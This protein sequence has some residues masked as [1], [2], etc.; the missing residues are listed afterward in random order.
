[1]SRSANILSNAFDMNMIL[2]GTVLMC[3]DSNDLDGKLLLLLLL[4]VFLLAMKFFISN[5]VVVDHLVRLFPFIIIVDFIYGDEDNGEV[6][7]TEKK[8]FRENKKKTEL[9]DLFTKLDAI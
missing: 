6:H 7:P 2:V 9:L 3:T 5:V 8:S 4:L 1:M